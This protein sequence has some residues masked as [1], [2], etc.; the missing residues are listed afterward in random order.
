MSRGY[1]DYLPALSLLAASALLA[2]A[3]LLEWLHFQ[4][5]RQEL[6]ERLAA[7]V[8]ARALAPLESEDNYALPAEDAFTEMTARPLF[9]DGRRPVEEAEEQASAAETE[10]TSLDFKLIGAVRVSAKQGQGLFQ[11]SKG[12]YLSLPICD[13][14]CA[15]NKDENQKDNAI[16]GWRLVEL[17]PAQY[18]ISERGLL[19]ETAPAKA[20]MEQGDKRQTISLQKTKRAAAAAPPTPP[21]PTGKGSVHKRGQ[22]DDNADTEESENIDNSE[23]SDD[24]EPT[25]DSSDENAEDSSDDSE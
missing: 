18:K 1:R 14:A 16:N 17:I 20:V 24:S 2:L 19:E 10:E 4:G 23:D 15:K 11:D 22:S 12:K 13:K 5:Q 3:L 8:E 6:R 21:K 7:K 9:M 25:D